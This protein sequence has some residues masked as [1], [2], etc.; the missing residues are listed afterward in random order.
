MN[1]D[2]IEGNWKHFK[3]GLRE[4]WGKLTGDAVERFDG[5]RERLAGV[6]QETRGIR[7]DEAERQV[8][9]SKARWRRESRLP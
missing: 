4:L 9:D 7:R 6:L 5:R 8:S 1:R 3:G 2:R